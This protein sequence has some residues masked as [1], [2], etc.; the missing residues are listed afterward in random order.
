V[1]GCRSSGYTAFGIRDARASAIRVLA[2]RTLRAKPA[3]ETSGRGRL[4]SPPCSRLM[5]ASRAVP[6]SFKQILSPL[7]DAILFV[8]AAAII[9][10]DVAV[11]E[12]LKVFYACFGGLRF[13]SKFS[14]P[15]FEVVPDFRTRGIRII[16][17]RLVHQILLKQSGPLGR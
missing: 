12:G 1:R 8:A 7:L 14:E 16:R 9:L 2:R 6:P 17:R 13:A 3:L 15:C 5:T 11:L 10:A 4:A